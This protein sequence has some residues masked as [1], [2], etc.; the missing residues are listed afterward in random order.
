[1]QHR[2]VVGALHNLNGILRYANIPNGQVNVAFVLI[3]GGNWDLI[4]P[5]IPMEEIIVFMPSHSF[6]HLINK[7][8]RKVV[9]TSGGIYFAIINANSNLYGKSGLH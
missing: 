5:G 4:I 7:W 6:Q 8:K 3:I 1:M 9:F 2:N